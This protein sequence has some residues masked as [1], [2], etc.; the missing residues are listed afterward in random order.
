MNYV[1]LG[2]AACAVA[3]VWLDPPTLAPVRRAAVQREAERDAGGGRAGGDWQAV[4]DQIPQDAIG[5]GNEDGLPLF[6]C[7]GAFKDGV[8]LGRVRADFHGC[9]VGYGGREVEVAPFEVLTPSWAE[10]S[11]GEAPAG[12]LPAGANPVLASVA[13][14]RVTPLLACRAAWRGSLQVGE[15]RDGGCVFGFGGQQV[16]AERYE[17]LMNSPWMTWAPAVPLAL[18]PGA[19]P[20]GNENGDKLFVCRAAAGGGLHVGK[21][22][23]SALGCNVTDGRREVVATRFEL[24]VPRWRT[25]TEGTLP[26]SALPQG[27]ENGASQYL[28]RAQ[29]SSTVQVGRVSENQAGC[30]I[31]VQGGEA[32]ATVYDVL[33]G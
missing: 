25:G 18:D 21:T 26:V 29:R 6:A 15:V 20:G 17:V 19:V 32:V 10:A 8:Q 27:R 3:T 30:H 24:L 22:R 7:R 31:G 23:Q 11:F 14:F 12:A 13:P 2:L 1:G 5:V 9:H 33:G 28:C 16:A 4:N